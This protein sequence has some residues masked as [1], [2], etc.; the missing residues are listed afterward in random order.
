KK[1]KNSNP[2]HRIFLLKNSL[3]MKKNK[4]YRNNRQKR[5]RQDRQQAMPKER[6]P[7]QR[8]RPKRITADSSLKFRTLRQAR[9]NRSM[10]GRNT[11]KRLTGLPTLW[12]ST[13]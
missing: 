9:V 10:Y 3:A 5:N 13:N 1:T 6:L 12:V 4:L 11:P 2:K 8:S 7:D